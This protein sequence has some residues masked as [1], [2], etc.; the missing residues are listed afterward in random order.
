MAEPRGS[1][2][3]GE[4]VEASRLRRKQFCEQRG[5]SLGLLSMYRKRHRLA[6]GG[7]EPKGRF[8]RVEVMIAQQGHG[9]SSC[10]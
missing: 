9:G 3:A 8:A 4:G 2:R 6:E 1:P 7:A 10:S 5:L